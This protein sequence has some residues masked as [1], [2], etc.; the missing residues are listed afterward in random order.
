MKTQWLAILMLP[1]LLH[2]APL[3]LAK[4]HKA[5]IDVSQYLIS[6][7]LDGVRARWT[8]E[9]LLSRY[10]NPIYSPT[11]FTES[12]PQTALDGELWIG[13]SAFQEVTRIVLDDIPDESE[14]TKI[15]FM[16]FDLPEHPGPFAERALDLKNLI[17]SNNTPHL[18]T[19]EQFEVHSREA[20]SKKLKEIETEGGEGLMLHHKANFYEDGR[21]AGLLKLKSFDDAEATVIAHHPGNGKYTDMLGSLEVMTGSGIRFKLGNGFSDDER[22]QPPPIGSQVTY[23]YFGLTQSGKP[24]F[25]S[26]LRI[27]EDQNH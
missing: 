20:L 16:A 23:K 11:W 8:G 22:R 10:G 12:F 6:E 17:E 24:R 27:R 25:A 2:A 3:M 13:R 5:E 26:F 7:K 1:S 9:E 18:K 15:T 19:V 14:W 4:T 21:S